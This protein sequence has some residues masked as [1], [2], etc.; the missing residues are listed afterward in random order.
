VQELKTRPVLSE[1]GVR[2]SGAVV[3]RVDDLAR[4]PGCSRS[5]VIR[6]AVDELAAHH[7]T[8][9]HPCLPTP[10]PGLDRVVQIRSTS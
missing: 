6:H 5:D 9:D 2:M 10:R 8:K 4:S 3:D 1:V 7:Q